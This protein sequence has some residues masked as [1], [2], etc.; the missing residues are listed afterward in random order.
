[1]QNHVR[2]ASI[3][4]RVIDD[5]PDLVVEFL[6]RV[7]GLTDAFSVNRHIGMNLCLVGDGVGAQVL[8]SKSPSSE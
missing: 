6:K 7:L 3:E 4:V 5:H 1:V 8:S 2:A